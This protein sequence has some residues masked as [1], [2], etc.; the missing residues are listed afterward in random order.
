MTGP[1]RPGESDE[2]RWQRQQRRHFVPSHEVPGPIPLNAVLGRTSALAV[3]LLA[4]RAFST[5]VELHLLTRLRRAGNGPDSALLHHQRGPVRN[6]G[7]DDVMHL[8]VLYPDGREGIAAAGGWSD[9]Q[10]EQVPLLRLT[11]GSSTPTQAD[12]RYWLTPLPPPGD[13]TVVFSWPY[14]SLT[15]TRTVIPA[16]VLADALTTA[17]ELWPYQPDPAFD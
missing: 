3:A 1:E 14:R 7:V 9:E 17:V 12:N 15:E 5:G 10:N 8:T 6:D 11:E 2:E 4:A 16:A 13:L